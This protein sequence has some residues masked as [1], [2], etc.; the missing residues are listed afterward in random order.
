M[1]AEII[2]IGDELLIG[3]VI[4]TNQA[5]IAEQLNLIGIHVER[6][7]TVGDDL[8]AILKA[9]EDACRPNRLV[10]ATGGLGPTHDD[11][12]KTAACRF[13]K[14]GLVPDPA[15]RTHIQSL[16]AKRNIPWS[17]AAESQIM[18]PE[19]AVVLHNPIGT[20]PGLHFRTTERE[21][22]LL[23]GVPY[24]MKEIVDRSMLPSLR[25][26]VDGFVIRHRTLRTTGISESLLAHHLGAI[27]DLLQGASL[28]F[29]P[30]PTGVR[31]RITVRDTD[32]AR[33]DRLVGEVEHRI[34]TRAAKYIYGTET[35]EL[36]EVLGALLTEQRKSIAV[37]ESCTGGMIANRITNVSGSSGYFERG[38][39]T[40]SNASKSNLLGVPPSLVE[41]HGAVSREVAEAMAA[42][43]RLL[44]GT[45][46][47]L[48]TTG[49]AGP[50]G[51]TTE[52][53]VGLVWIGYSDE[54]A[55]FAL[56]FQFGD[57]RLRFKERASQAAL[58]LVRRRLLTIE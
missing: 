9:F 23:P 58:E 51:G 57:G 45:D 4:N 11:I 5:Y 12:T 17:D 44:A 52:K 30:S 42:G 24:E 16:L 53:P 43:V 55:T 25:D 46:I 41:L 7:T 3:Q 35:Q 13:F 54:T 36:E 14:C 26:R 1:N 31:L 6:M 18:V 49:I 2:T 32:A 48:S 10:V 28:A 19:N 34:R 40:Y 8:D 39:I 33:A 56:K 15:V 29:L 22:Y 20:A 47:G 27:D 50:T 37:A 21:L 38:I